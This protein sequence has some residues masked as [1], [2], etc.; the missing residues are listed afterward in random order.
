[1]YIAALAPRDGTAPHLPPGGCERA[2]ERLAAFETAM[3]A[4]RT[5]DG[6]APA[7]TE[8]HAEGALDG[9]LAESLAAGLLRRDA[10]GRFALTLRG[11]LLSN[12]VFGRLLP[13][14]G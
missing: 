14:A 12:E 5:A 1:M 3:L 11:R 7:A 8:L 6:W 2:D 10:A 13:A 9:H 4:L